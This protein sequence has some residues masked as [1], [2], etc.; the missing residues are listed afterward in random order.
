MSE[1]KYGLQL[2][3][4]VRV[5]RKDKDIDGKNGKVFTVTDVWFNTS[6]KDEKGEWFNIST[7]LIFPRNHQLPE[8]NSVIEILEAFP[9]ITGQ[10]KYRRMVFYVKGWHYADGKNNQHLD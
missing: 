4:I 10:G 1:Q 5:F 7:N 3:G 6:E 8:N 2:T 9:M